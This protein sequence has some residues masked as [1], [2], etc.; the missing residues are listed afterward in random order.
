MGCSSEI[1]IAPTWYTDNI[2]LRKAFRMGNKSEEDITN[3]PASG[4]NETHLNVFKKDVED[5]LKQAHEMLNEV[6]VKY[7][8]LLD[9]LGI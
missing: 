3:T 1:S 2:M 6:E 9:K 8:A 7:Q 4:T 5:A